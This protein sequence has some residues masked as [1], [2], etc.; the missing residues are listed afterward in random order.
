MNIL[1]KLTIK[2]LKLNKKRT[3]VTIIGIILSTALICAVAGM[4]SSVQQT[5][6]NDAIRDGGNQHIT[7]YNVKNEDLKYYV[8]DRNV[9]SYY[10][11]QN[12]G[13]AKLENTDK[14][15]LYIRAYTAD[16]LKQAG[17]ELTEGRFANNANEIVITNTIQNSDVSFKIGDILTLDVG[18][19]VL[20]EDGSTLYQYNSRTHDA[21][22]DI[23][24][25]VQKTYT[26]VGFIKRPN[27][28]VEGV[29]SPGYTALTTMEESTLKEADIS[30]LFKNPNYAKEF[31]NRLDE[32]E[33][34]YDYSTN[35]ELLRW[36]LVNLSSSVMLT[37]M[38]VAGV[39]IGIIILTSIF[40]IRNSFNISISEK[41]R[42]YGML[43]SIGATSKQIKKNVLYEG[44][45]IGL[46]GIPIG[47]L[48]GM[49][50]D[51]VLVMIINWLLGPSLNGIEFIYKIPILPIIITIALA[52]ITI[53]LSVISAARKSSKISPIE[54]IRS[55]DD[56]K[57][58]SKKLKTPKIIKKI[59]KMGGVIA[60]KNLKR[61][62]KKYRTTVISL[63][64]SIAVFISLS[65]F[66]TYGFKMTGIY[67]K[68]YSY[69]I[70]V[71]V[72]SKNNDKIT[73]QKI[74][75]D[76]L[77]MDNVDKY[78]QHN[79]AYIAIDIKDITT[80]DVF[81]SMKGDTKDTTTDSIVYLNV[82]SLG[83]DEY[84]RYVKKIGGTI[85]A[86]KN[87]G[88]LIDNITSYNNET[89]KY[90][91][92]NAYTLNVGDSIT[93]KAGLEDAPDAKKVTIPIV[94]KTEERPMGLENSYSMS[95]YLIVSDE[96][97]D[98]IGAEYDGGLF[99]YS[100]DPSKLSKS[101]DN[102][103]TANTGNTINYLNME[104][105][106]KQEN[107][108][109]LLIAIFL[110]GFIAVISLIGVTNIFNTITT[111]M[112]LRQKEFA[113]LKSIG[114]TSKEFNRMILLES[115][116]YCSKA[117]FI[118]VPIGL[119]GSYLIYNGFVNTASFEYII[120]I[121]SILISIG[122]VFLLVGL[123]MH[124]SFKK[125]NKQNIIE[126]IRKDNI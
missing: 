112:M 93:E 35:K 119:V 73:A 8:N 29:S 102:Y 7:L 64:V 48:S 26:I 114:M 24:N 55:N 58:K 38:T 61:S 99:I 126:T 68:E 86:Y 123:I 39:V 56:I 88:I 81:F 95:G 31:T 5:L 97:M 71:A 51:F 78:S 57:I 74:Y 72:A 84:E 104:E 30:L 60:H 121:S 83:N 87:G 118:G 42:Q 14:P 103:K 80:D 115:I 125:I 27:Y 41:T 92:I 77:K 15:Y 52:S 54:A 110:Y 16:G 90:E 21:P 3:I 113:M 66:I 34:S 10:L 117:L 18:N 2:S 82:I 108:M 116:F 50:A 120:P 25:T 79:F 40:V 85:D 47:V 122:A 69:N 111:N 6:I 70:E 91:F 67:Y 49:F 109:V 65:S 13:Y 43:A 36:Q 22:E 1:N 45:I 124:Y 100:S 76:I 107:S 53:Y 12:L 75:D 106:V 62:R 19:R 101:I 59:F 105:M 94:A 98:S 17:Y 44:L 89:K 11:A 96:M 46:F 32:D 33:N 37:L 28:N 63:V 23:I 9:E 20:L 4:V